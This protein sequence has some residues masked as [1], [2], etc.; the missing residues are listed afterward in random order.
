MLLNPP[1][2]L[3]V[4]LQ[5]LFPALAVLLA[6]VHDLVLVHQHSHLVLKLLAKCLHLQLV[7]G[8]V[9]LVK[10]RRVDNLV[11][12]ALHVVQLYVR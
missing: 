4:L 6:L 10:K 12:D 11:H 3:A 1:L 7:H 8:E 9:N 2:T 5:H